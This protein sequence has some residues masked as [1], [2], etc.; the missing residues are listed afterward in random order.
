MRCSA[1]TKTGGQCR[2]AKELTF[3][4]VSPPAASKML[5]WKHY[6]TVALC[7]KHWNEARDLA[8]AREAELKERD[9]RREGCADCMKVDGHLECTMNCGPAVKR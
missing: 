3:I 5:I 1:H 9:R 7:P 6:L 8:D 2:A 4:L